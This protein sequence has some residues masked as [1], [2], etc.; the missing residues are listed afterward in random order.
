[1]QH[2]MLRKAIF[3]KKDLKVYLLNNILGIL[4]NSCLFKVEAFSDF[5]FS[6]CSIG[7][8]LFTIFQNDFQSVQKLFIQLKEN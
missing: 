5:L 6:F 7:S 1:M 8:G 3:N 2:V 4:E